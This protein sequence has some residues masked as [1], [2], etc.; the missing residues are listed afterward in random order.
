MRNIILF[1]ATYGSGFLFIVL[2]ILCFTMIV[3]YNQNQKSIYLNSANILSG[4]IY[5]ETQGFV[6][7]FKASDLSDSLHRENT[8]LQRR[9]LYYEG[10]GKSPNIS[11]E[12]FPFN[13]YPAKVINQSIN[14]RNN[15]LT[16]DKGLADGIKPD[17]AVISRD[18][19]VGIVKSV[20]RNYALVLS[21]LNSN[22]RISAKL[23]RN[24]V[25]GNLIWED[26][27]PERMNLEA[28]PTHAEILIGDTIVTSGFSTIFPNNIFIGTIENFNIQKG[29]ANYNISVKLNNDL[30]S[31]EYVYI[32]ENEE[33]DSQIQVEDLQ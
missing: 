23:R 6:D 14:T 21:I 12:E 7:F 9:L 22:S 13:F 19:I 3:N 33:K 15:Y 32:I 11:Q 24:N 28:V 10:Y 29:A 27:D 25:F 4:K 17:M 2:E 5:K 18:G 20:N 1:F 16:I 31:T 26:L 30:S 8:E